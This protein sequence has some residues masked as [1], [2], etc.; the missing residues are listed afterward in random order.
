MPLLCSNSAA[1]SAHS[2]SKLVYIQKN[3]AASFRGHSL[4]HS[5]PAILLIL[6]TC[7]LS[8]AVYLWQCYAGD[9]DDIRTCQLQKE[10]LHQNARGYKL[11][12]VRK[13]W[14]IMRGATVEC[15]VIPVHF[16]ASI[17]LRIGN[18]CQF[19]GNLI[20]WKLKSYSSLSM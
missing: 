6:R 19:G 13:G 18:Y 2:N 3:H 14:L 4:A 8:I 9:T 17:F 10:I 5:H 15:T 7:L 11:E 20:L 16:A 1:H 12:Y